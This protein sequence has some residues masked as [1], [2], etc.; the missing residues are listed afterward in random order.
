LRSGG[1]ALSEILEVGVS[2]QTV[3]K[4]ET[5]LGAAFCASSHRWYSVQYATQADLEAESSAL[6]WNVHSLRSDAPSCC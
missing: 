6:C 1:T 5:M 4:A 2:R 3:Y